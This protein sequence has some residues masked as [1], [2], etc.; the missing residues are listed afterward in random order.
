MLAKRLREI[1]KERG[2]RQE[3]VADHLGVKRQTYSAYERA[4]SVPDS[5]TLK[6]LADFFDVTVDEFFF[7]PTEDASLEAQERKV[8]LLARKTKR[9]PPDQRERLFR[10]FEANIDL[11]LDALGLQDDREEEVVIAEEE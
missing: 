5:L 4:V 8:T 6:K 9:I 7:D 1:R 11:Y 3:E 2:L 10:N